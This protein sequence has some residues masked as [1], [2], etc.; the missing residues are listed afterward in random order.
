[1]ILEISDKEYNSII[2]AIGAVIA[3]CSKERLPELESIYSK[4][5]KLKLDEANREKICV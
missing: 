3:F 2:G 4:L 1:M 5:L